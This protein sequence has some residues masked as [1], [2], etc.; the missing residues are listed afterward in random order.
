MLYHITYVW[1]PKN[2]TNK[3]I[4]KTETDLQIWK[5]N[6]WLPKGRGEWGETNWGYGISRHKLLY[7]KIDHQQ[8]Y[9]I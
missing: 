4:C 9:T 3:C 6:L 5:T 1:N 2:N 7:I 8:G